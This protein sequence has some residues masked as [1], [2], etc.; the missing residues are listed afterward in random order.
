ML[1]H[2]FLDHY[3]VACLVT[4][5][6]DYI[7]LVEEVKRAWEDCRVHVLRQRTFGMNSSGS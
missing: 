7:P 2:A 4:G 3:E 6:A 5:D 1:S